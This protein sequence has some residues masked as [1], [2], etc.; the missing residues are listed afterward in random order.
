MLASPAES[1]TDA[2]TELGGD[3]SVEYKLDGARIQVHR[4]GD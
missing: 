2:W 4:N 3:V 1:L